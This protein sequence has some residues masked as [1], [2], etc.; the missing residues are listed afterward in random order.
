MTVYTVDYT[1]EIDTWNGYVW[2]TEQG[3]TLYATKEL[4]Q[5]EC[6]KLNDRHLNFLWTTYL[7]AAKDWEKRRAR[8]Q[9][10]VLGGFEKAVPPPFDR[11]FKKFEVDPRERYSV[12]EH[13]VVTK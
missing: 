9:H 12:S 6:D 1:H 13:E 4:A 11:P 2:D 5:A 7:R 8:Y 10:L 3:E